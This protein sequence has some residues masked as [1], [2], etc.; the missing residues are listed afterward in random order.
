MGYVRE[1]TNNLQVSSI[2]PDL[3][4]IPG[5]EWVGKTAYMPVDDNA[6]EG[7]WPVTEV[8]VRGWMGSGVGTNWLGGA[9]NTKTFFGEIVCGLIMSKIEHAQH[10]AL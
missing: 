2:A 1:A 4:I 5:R 9:K 3:R 7:G 10:K 8:G 6:G